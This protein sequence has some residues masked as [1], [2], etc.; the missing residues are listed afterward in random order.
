MMSFIPRQKTMDPNV[1]CRHAAASRL[2]IELGK[3]SHGGIESGHF[4]MVGDTDGMAAWRERF[5]NRDAFRSSVAFAAPHVGDSYLVEVFFRVACYDLEQARK[6]GVDVIAYLSERIGVPAESVEI[7]FSGSRSFHVAVS[8]M[9][10]GARPQMGLLTMCRR[11]AGQLQAEG[12]RDIDLSIY[13]P[14]C[15]TRLPNSVNSRTDLH[16]IPLE[17]KELR[18][19]NADD[20]RSLAREPRSE[21][22]LAI[23]EESER[24]AAWYRDA[25][26]TV[27]KSRP[28]TTRTADPGDRQGWLF[29]GI[30]PGRFQIQQS[31]H[32][33]MR[34]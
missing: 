6:D 16:A 21:D 4:V 27:L 1:S 34:P 5:G 20:I 30:R 24:A 28:P 33:T 8:L 32:G 15:L 31:S 26:K 12:I 3:V 18:D 17:Y 11:L 23:V 9:V 10:F 7:T 2:W 22:S 25:V 13:H 29:D 19:F 14:S